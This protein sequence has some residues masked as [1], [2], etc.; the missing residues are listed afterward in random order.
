[1]YGDNE[2]ALLIVSNIVFYGKTK[3]IK[4]NFH[5]IQKKLLSKEMFVEFV[6]SND[7]LANVLT[8]SLRGPWIEFIR[9]RF[10]ANNMDIPA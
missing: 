1:M 6:R 5:F 8:K 4:I 2:V 7:F 10:G 9:S 3:N